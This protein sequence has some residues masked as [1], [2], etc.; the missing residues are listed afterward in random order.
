VPEPVPGLH[1]HGAPEEHLG[2]HRAHHEAAR[3]DAADGAREGLDRSVEVL[4]HVEQTHDVVAPAERGGA[5]R[6][7]MDQ[8][9]S[10]GSA[11]GR[12]LDQPAVAVDPGDVVAGRRQVRRHDPAAAAQ[13]EDPPRRRRAEGREAARDEAVAGPVPEVGALGRRQGLLEALVGHVEPVVIRVELAQ[14]LDVGQGLHRGVLARRLTD[15]RASATRDDLA[16]GAGARCPPNAALPLCPPRCA[17]GR[18]VEG[19]TQKRLKFPL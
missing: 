6:E 3:T 1:V 7:I 13:L 18:R 12:P 5:T 4:E 9:A 15:L 16:A 14:D 2:G 17:G 11:A 19:S 10:P 8:K